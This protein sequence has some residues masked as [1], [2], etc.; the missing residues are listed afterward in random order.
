MDKRRFRLRADRWKG[1]RH[2]VTKSS[3]CYTTFTHR[4]PTLQ[5][6]AY[7]RHAAVRRLRLPPRRAGTADR[8]RRGADH[9]EAM[10]SKNAILLSN[11][12]L[13]TAGK[14]IE[15]ATLLAVW[16]EH[17][18]AMQLRARAIGEIKPIAPELAIESRDFLRKPKILSLTFAY[19][20]RR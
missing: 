18:A 15:E 20:A 17:A 11:H 13:L 5:A 12:G 4:R 1:G 16:M 2:P 8:R 9:L 3:T 6:R 14:T 7:G 19:Y 10:G